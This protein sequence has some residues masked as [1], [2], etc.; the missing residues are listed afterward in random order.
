MD[1]RWSIGALAFCAFLTWSASQAVAQD[2]AMCLPLTVINGQ[3]LN[4]G[5]SA[6]GHSQEHPGTIAISVLPGPDMRDNP[7][8]LTR[9][10]RSVGNEAD[11]FIN[12]TYMED[13]GTL[14][15][16]YVAGQRVTYDGHTVFGIQELRDNPE[17]ITVARGEAALAKAAFGRGDLN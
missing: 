2:N 16:L 5:A 12:N 14:I 11:C 8:G 10:L 1:T 15:S 7:S 3:T 6:M 9:Y 13:N 17:I 4:S